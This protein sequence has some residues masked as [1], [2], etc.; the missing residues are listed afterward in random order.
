LSAVSDVKLVVTADYH[1]HDILCRLN[2]FIASTCR[3]ALIRLPNKTPLKDFLPV[4]AQ[5]THRLVIIKGV[6]SF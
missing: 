4:I 3:T 2:P 1:T 5:K 6:G